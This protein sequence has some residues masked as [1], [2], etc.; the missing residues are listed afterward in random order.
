[1]QNPKCICHACMNEPWIWFDS[2]L[3]KMILIAS[4]WNGLNLRLK[5]QRSQRKIIEFSVL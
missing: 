4:H 5:S 1:M 2:I 3:N